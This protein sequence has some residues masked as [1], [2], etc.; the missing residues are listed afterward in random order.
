V[1]RRYQKKLNNGDN[2][3]NNAEEQ[4]RKSMA[5][6]ENKALGGMAKTYGASVIRRACIENNVKISGINCSGSGRDGE[7]WLRRARSGVVKAKRIANSGTL[8]FLKRAAGGRRK[9]RK[10]K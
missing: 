9:R 3:I 7:R 10:R 2:K 4:H 6:K 8:S 1:K 5:M